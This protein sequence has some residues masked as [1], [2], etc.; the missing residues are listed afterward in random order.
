[1]ENVVEKIKEIVSV[2]TEE[3]IKIIAQIFANSNYFKEK[4]EETKDNILK[5]TL[6]ARWG[7]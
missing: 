4:F 2:A 7:I 5:S 3:D 6:H 1:M